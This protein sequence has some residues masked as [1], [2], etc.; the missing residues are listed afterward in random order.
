MGGAPF[1]K[2]KFPFEKRRFPFEKRKF[3][4]IELV[5][6]VGLGVTWGGTN[7]NPAGQTHGPSTQQ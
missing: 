6:L 3:P 7:L 1:E 5:F 2:R 4:T